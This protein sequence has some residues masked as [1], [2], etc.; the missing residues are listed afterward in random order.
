MKIGMSNWPAGIAVGLLAGSSL[1]GGCA[2]GPA[3]PDL[4]SSDRNIPAW[5]WPTPA[6]GVPDARPQTRVNP[7][8]AVVQPGAGYWVVQG[9]PSSDTYSR[10]DASLGAVYTDPYQSWMGWPTEERPSLDNRRSF[11]S[12]RSAERYVYPSTR[13]RDRRPHREPYWSPRRHV[14]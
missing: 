1:L 11:T 7:G 9:D 2:S 5:N 13:E 14:R 4:R 3:A 8:N 12:G 6:P 10:R